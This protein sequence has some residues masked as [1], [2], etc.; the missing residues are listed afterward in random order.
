MIDDRLVFL[1][2]NNHVDFRYFVRNYNYIMTVLDLCSCYNLQTVQN[3]QINNNNINFDTTS[4]DTNLAYTIPSKT[5]SSYGEKYNIDI[6]DQ[7]NVLNI[8]L[9]VSTA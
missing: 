9:R 2:Q 3:L 8:N 7:G 1:Q 5:K 4:T 6:I